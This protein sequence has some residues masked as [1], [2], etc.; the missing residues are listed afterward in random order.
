MGAL[1]LR[2]WPALRVVISSLVLG[3]M[4]A[5]IGTIALFHLDQ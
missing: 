5:G 1:C 2:V 3:L 4:L